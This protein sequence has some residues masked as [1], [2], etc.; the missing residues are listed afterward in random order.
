ML[1]AHSFPSPLIRENR[2]SSEPFSDL[3]LVI[4]GWRLLDHP[5]Y[6]QY[7]GGNKETQGT[8][9]LVIPQ[10][11]SSLGN[12]LYPFTFQGLVLLA[13]WLCPRFFNSIRE[14][15][16]EEW[17]YSCLARTGC[18][19]VL[20]FMF[21]LIIHLMIFSNFCYNCLFDSWII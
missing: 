2:L 11:P 20:I 16:W 5:V 15:S 21:F 12:Q 9:Y 7:M 18:P 19:Q 13:V 8:Q 6:R 17:V 4:L 14:P 1:S 3:L 10:V